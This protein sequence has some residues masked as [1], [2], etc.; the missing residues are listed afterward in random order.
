MQDKNIHDIHY[1]IGFNDKQGFRTC[2][3]NRFIK[4][5]EQ[6]E[7]PE[8]CKTIIDQRYIHSYGENR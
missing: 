6:G 7:T 8:L 2:S 1:S 5:I 3:Y 4:M